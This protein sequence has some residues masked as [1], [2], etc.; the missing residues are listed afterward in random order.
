MNLSAG[1]FHD[2]RNK[3]TAPIIKARIV[4]VLLITVD[5]IQ[6]TNEAVV[7]IQQFHH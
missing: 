1:N 5:N 7:R 4:F 2:K 6:T 3:V